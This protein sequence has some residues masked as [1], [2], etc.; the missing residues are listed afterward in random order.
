MTDFNQT[1]ENY[2]NCYEA[3]LNTFLDKHKDPG[4]EELDFIKK[5]FEIWGE[6][7]FTVRH[8][9]SGYQNMPY[10]DN[11]NYNQLR[12]QHLVRTMSSDSKDNLVFRSRAIL[13]FLSEKLE[14][15][16]PEISKNETKYTTSQYALYHFYLQKAG[17]EEWFEKSQSKTIG[18]QKVADAYGL[19]HNNFRNLYY[20]IEKDSIRISAEKIKDIKKAIELLK[21]NN[22]KEAVKI[23]KEE[24]NK[25]EM[26]L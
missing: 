24:L 5:E 19:S 25:A 4:V 20:K 17:N 3:N 1:F 13:K 14:E 21:E 6:V 15:I 10:G 2:K 23:A 11:T 9:G 7:E 18:M 26:K 16:S 8:G 22:H 12:I